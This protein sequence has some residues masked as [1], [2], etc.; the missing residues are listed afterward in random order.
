MPSKG[1]LNLFLKDVS[2][3]Q[4]SEK[5]GVDIAYTSRCLNKGLKASRKLV[6]ASE[7]L[8]FKPEDLFENY[9]VK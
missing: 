9:T 4:L 3:K 7:E 8:G 5:A 1:R 6:K 2:I